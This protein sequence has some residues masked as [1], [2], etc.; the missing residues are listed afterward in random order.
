MQKGKPQNLEL[1]KRF[2]RI[3]GQIDG[4]GRMLSDKRT[5]IA[6]V[7]QIIAIRAAL[8]RFGVEILKDESLTCVKGKKQETILKNLNSLFKLI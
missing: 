4:V 7:Q 3:K 6:I 8:A 5:C 2:N 1:Q